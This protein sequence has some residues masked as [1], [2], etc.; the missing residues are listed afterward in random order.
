M[1]VWHLS[2]KNKNILL[3]NRHTIIFLRRINS[4]VKYLLISGLYSN[5]LDLSTCPQ[6]Q[7]A[8]C[9][10]LVF[11]FLNLG[12]RQG[13]FIIFSCYISFNLEQTLAF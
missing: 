4:A 9:S 2:S 10:F 3:H 7:M 8:H 11:L 13:S 5:I 6:P 12:S 1:M